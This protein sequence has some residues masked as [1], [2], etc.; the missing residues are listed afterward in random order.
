MKIKYFLPAMALPLMVAC[1]QEE[2]VEQVGTE[3]PQ[4]ERVSAG[5]VSFVNGTAESR[6]NYYTQ[7]WEKGDKFNLFLMDQFNEDSDPAYKE[8]IDEAQNANKTWFMDQNVWNKMYKISNYYQANLPFVFDGTK[9]ANDDAS[10]EGNYIAVAPSKTRQNH[11]DKLTNRRDVWLYINPVQTLTYNKVNSGSIAGMEENQFFLGYTQIYRNQQLNTESG[12]LQ[13]PINMRPILA[14]VD[15]AIK[16]VSEESFRV[17]KMVISRKDGGKMPTIAYVRPAGNTCESFGTRQD[18]QT[19][20]FPHQWNVAT[21]ANLAKWEANYS[22]T[23]NG[24]SSWQKLADHTDAYPAFAQPYIINKNMPAGCNYGNGMYW[25]IDTWTRSAARSVVEY[26][27][28]GENGLTP[29]ACKGEMAGVAYEYVIQFNNASNKGYVELGTKEYIRAMITLPHDMDLHD[30]QITV[31]GQQED[32]ARDRWNEGIIIPDFKGAYTVPVEGTSATENDGRFTL[33]NIDLGSERDYLEANISFSDFKVGRSRIVSTTNSEDLLKHLKSYYGENAEADLNKNTLFYVEAL[34]DFEVTNELVAYV[35][36]LVNNYNANQGSKVGIYF[37]NVTDGGHIIFPANLTATN[38]IDLFFYNNNVGIINEGTQIINRAITVA[39]TENGGAENNDELIDWLE[40]TLAKGLN[41]GV[42]HID[43]AGTLTINADV[44]TAEETSSIYNYEGATLTI[45]KKAK[46]YGNSA[47][48]KRGEKNAKVHNDGTLI[49]KDATI[50]GLLRNNNYVEVSGAATVNKLQNEKS[51]GCFTCT[52]PAKAVVDIKSGSLTVE[53]EK[54]SYN[55]SEIN[56]NAKF[57]VVAPWF[58]N[59]ATINNLGTVVGT[60]SNNT[61]G[62]F[63][64]GNETVAGI[65]TG[66]LANSGKV[67]ATKGEINYLWN[68]EAGK[69]YVMKAE[70]NSVRT[71]ADSEGTIIF[72]GVEAQHIGTEGQDLRVYELAASM[73]L[74]DLV[75]TMKATNTS[76]IKTAFDIVV[77]AYGDKAYAQNNIEFLY[78]DGAKVDIVGAEDNL[79]PVL[80]SLDIYL[81]KNAKGEVISQL[82]IE[83]NTTLVVEGIEE[84]SRPYVHIATGSDLLSSINNTQFTGCIYHK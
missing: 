56:N 83:G 1:S 13:L 39:N 28:P 58:E 47:Y 66:R 33:Q 5:K 51:D 25:T 65:V 27:Y 38:A 44:V 9:W 15:L 50:L 16:N 68:S 2:L 17:E 77:D 81:A 75:L 21:T 14:N 71:I 69:L 73:N 6:L 72:K 59:N 64:N 35:Q 54:D 79:K 8:W 24:A 37:T 80:S 74:S 78:V 70:G 45:A 3:A 52:K 12:E 49:M 34:N 32:S 62:V 20:F 19:S 60:I 55:N 46:I 26:S 11:L 29:Y 7:T 30:Y 82:H 63:N 40:T 10:S 18:D 4:V 53:N 76:V 67:Y 23:L 57:E 36:K 31:Y 41:F 84:A 42:A 43:N 48:S 61:K 22:G